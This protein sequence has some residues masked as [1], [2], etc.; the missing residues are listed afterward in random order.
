MSSNT[1]R[2]EFSL[3][4][5]KPA[6]SIIIPAY[7]HLG[8]CLVPCIESIKKFT[9]LS[10]VE[11][12]VVANGCG[13]DGTR[14]YVSGCGE[15][16]R[17]IWIEEQVGY[18][19]AV[20]RGIEQAKGEY[21]ILLNNDTVLL[22][23]GKNDW[24]NILAHPFHTDAHVAVTGPM[25]TH[26][27]EADRDFLIFFCVM[28]KKQVF[29]RIG[30]LDEAFAP[31]YGEDTDF[32]CRAEDA[33]YKIVQVPSE[34]K[35]YYDHNRMT[36]QFPIYHEGNVSYKNWVGGEELLRKN[37]EILRT[38]YNKKYRLENKEFA[39]RQE[40][41]VV[42]VTAD[43][44]DVTAGQVDISGAKRCDGFM[45]DTELT[46]L[47]KAASKLKQN[48][49][50][51]EVGSW[52]GKSSRAIADH[53]SEGSVLYCIDTWNG[54]K[55]EQDTS[56]ASAKMMDGDHA[57]YEFLQNNFDHVQS[58]RII[59]I[60]MSSVNGSKIFLEKAQL[61][62]MIF[63]DAG[64]TYDEVIEDIQA[65]QKVVKPGG[66]FCGHDYDQPIWEGVQRAV[67]KLLPKAKNKWEESGTI[68][69]LTHEEPKEPDVAVIV[70]THNDLERL[71]RAL[72]TIFDQD[73]KNILVIVIDDSSTDGTGEYLNELK[74]NKRLVGLRCEAKNPAQARN[75]GLRY[76]QGIKSIK[77]IAYC[78]SDDS[79]S[80]HHL[81]NSILNIKEFNAD[82]VYCDC[83]FYSESGGELVSLNPDFQPYDYARLLIGNFIYISS[84]V[85]RIE[86]TNRCGYFD[87][88]A[89][90]M[91]DWDMW[92]RIGERFS[93]KKIKAA[94]VNYLCKASGHSATDRIS[95]DAKNYIQSKIVTQTIA[96][97]Q[98]DQQS[99]LEV[100]SE[101]DLQQQKR[102]M[103]YDCFPFFNEL[104]VLDIRLSTMDK[105]ADRFVIVE[106]TRTH[107]NNPKP[108]YF[109]NNMHRY[110]KYLHKI[111]HIVV[112]DYPATDSWSIERHQRD[113]IMRGL[114][115]CNANDTI[116]I[117]D[118]DEIP[119]PHKVMDYVNG[120]DRTV[121]ALS[122]KLYYYNF[123]T[124]ASDPW[125]EAKIVG[126]SQL[127]ALT[128]CGVRY[129]QCEII[130]NAGW[131]FSYFKDIDGIV[132]KLNATAHAEYNTPFYKDKDRI[133]QAVSQGKDLFGRDLKYTSL[134]T[135]RN[136]YGEDFYPQYVL[137]NY[138]HYKRLG[139]FV[140]EHP[141]RQRKVVVVMPYY[142]RA[143]QLKK[144]ME[145]IAQTNYENY[146]VV[147]VDDGSDD[148]F[149]KEVWHKHIV[150]I[151]LKE[152][153][154][155]NPVIALNRG[156]QY[157]IDL[158]AEII[159]LMNSECYPVGDVISY[160]AKHV[161]D[162]NYLSFSCY[163]L[164][165]DNTFDPE[166]D[167]KLHRIIRDNNLW[168]VK[169]GENSWYNHPVYRPVGYEFC[170]AI[171]VKNM[172]AINGYDERFAQGVA[173]ADKNLL[174]RIEKSGLS[175]RI[176]E[177]PFV[178]H[179]WHYSGK[180]MYDS[181]EL[182]KRNEQ[183]YDITDKEQTTVAVH[184]VN[185]PLTKS[186][187]EAIV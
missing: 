179:Q 5:S 32:C 75:E 41:K 106:A 157:A 170:S 180:S 125:N 6:Y 143:E 30:L 3:Q 156:I 104:E 81:S 47:A 33:G 61:A 37:N 147:I 129:S 166:I 48:S 150:R 141:Q 178:V 87:K 28:I 139:F 149:I 52:H 110:K 46:W 17:V 153:N 58:G 63:I 168:A 138:D 83:R 49:I 115:H 73:Y 137:D 18:T 112:D 53:L 85:H 35:E 26:C 45:S 11:V 136:C 158:G 117:S 184:T 92:I 107:Q 142:N 80:R 68:W 16:F 21:L 174:M 51:I 14:Q 64:H 154:W 183:L 20:N 109:K 72:A 187:Q 39:P 88:K 152:K 163:S 22:G 94:N 140:T 27:P 123:N 176:I 126:Y 128:P 66:I 97:L 82:M 100:L 108:L 1:E 90:P 29:D 165:K 7:K 186:K 38:R 113:A 145:K 148:P 9:D 173:Y 10:N 102:G 60:R 56:H 59:P 111:T 15:A 42:D 119:D 44:V 25:K 95:I 171:T 118:C 34:S 133:K 182:F 103:V 93:I 131:H 2:I 122:Q 23:Q 120:K 177:E 146:E 36:G 31:A 130:P 116:I 135:D 50:V 164:S 98:Q 175:L 96:P 78:D 77:Y 167:S 99:A 71:K 101:N 114:I 62:D 24:I 132:E 69:H 8:D 12:L 181:K 13:D 155:H 4:V 121:K 160:A 84:V 89:Y 43:Q 54:S 55:V 127:K 19:K 76:A 161:N 151:D 169:E 144:T 40:I 91:E 67:N 185:P 65:W 159:M 172:I 70:P 79:W 162:N 105:V 86:C 124:L 134:D 57:F 74:Q